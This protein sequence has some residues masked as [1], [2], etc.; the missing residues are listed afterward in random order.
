MSEFLTWVLLEGSHRLDFSTSGSKRRSNMS[1]LYAEIRSSS[2]CCAIRG[3]N[4][5]DIK[6]SELSL[7]TCQRIV[8]VLHG[9]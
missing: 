5:V 4:V 6:R 7:R 2:K 3:G 9:A 8:M 1:F